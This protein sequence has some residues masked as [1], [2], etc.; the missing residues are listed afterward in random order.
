M[1][2]FTLVLELHHVEVAVVGAHQVRLR[3]AAH[4]SHVLDR[5]HWHGGIL[6][7]SGQQSAFS[8]QPGH[9][10]ATDAKGATEMEI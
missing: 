8:T 5:F 3:S 1:W 4:P 2:S 6:A 9:S 10:T 7:L